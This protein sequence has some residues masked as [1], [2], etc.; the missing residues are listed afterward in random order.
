MPIYKTEARRTGSKD[1][2]ISSKM[3][4]LREQLQKTGFRAHVLA[5]YTKMNGVA[6]R[7]V[8]VY[9]AKA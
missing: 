5:G 3:F 9:F 8:M 1:R 4:S 6:H 2:K 7:K